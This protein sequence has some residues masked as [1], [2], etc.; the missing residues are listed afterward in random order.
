MVKN[1]FPKNLQRALSDNKM[2]QDRLA[3]HLNTTQQ[4]ISRWVTGIKEPDF[5][6]LFEICILHDE[7]P[8]SLLGFDETNI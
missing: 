4:T 3:K 6:T 1:Q 2:S 8:N 7:T 5:G